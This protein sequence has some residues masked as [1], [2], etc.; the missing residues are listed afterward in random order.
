MASPD[1]NSLVAIFAQPDLDGG[2]DP[3][4]RAH[5]HQLGKKRPVVM[6]AFPPKA[7]GTYFRAAMIHAVNG[8]LVR[9]VHALGGRDATPY[10]PT[11]IEYYAGGVTPATLVTHVHMQALTAN[12]HFLEAFDIRPI[13]MMRSIPDMLASYWDMLDVDP[14]AHESGLNCLIPDDFSEMSRDKKAD[15]LVDVLGPWYASFFATWFR[16]HSESPDRVCMLSYRQFCS[17]PAGTLSRA[18]SHAGLPR[19]QTDCRSALE[20]AW[21]K[22]GKLRYNKGEEGRGA[23]YFSPAHFKWLA[24]QLGAYRHLA[25]HRDELLASGTPALAHAV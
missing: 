13:V 12:I 17:D 7:A 20:R 2:Y 23:Q 1:N 8:Q 5:L 11:F 25:P 3:A 6:L 14:A 16:Y 18:L 4:T 21:A 9:T 15:F 19:S 10:L 22:R 24:R